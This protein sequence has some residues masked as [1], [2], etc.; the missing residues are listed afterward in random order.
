[1]SGRLAIL[2]GAALLVSCSAQVGTF[3]LVSPGTPEMPRLRQR[4]RGVDCAVL[5]LV[6]PTPSL[7]RAVERAVEQVPWGEMLVDVTVTNDFLVTGV[8][9]RSCYRVEGEVAGSASGR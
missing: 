2:L 6:M 5:P 1:M 3:T 7:Q 4:V 9:N 8:Y